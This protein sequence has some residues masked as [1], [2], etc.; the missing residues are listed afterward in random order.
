M[1]PTKKPTPKTDFCECGA[2]FTSRYNLERHLS[3]KV[4][5]ISNEALAPPSKKPK[6][7]EEHFNA[8]TLKIRDELTDLVKNLQCCEYV[9]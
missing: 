3:N 6:T 1:P 7:S 4:C 5:Y 9:K 2:G 8:T